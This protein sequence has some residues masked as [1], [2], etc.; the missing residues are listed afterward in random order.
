MT[1]IIIK[2]AK[3]TDGV[4]IR[5]E[6]APTRSWQAFSVHGLPPLLSDMEGKPVSLAKAVQTWNSSVAKKAQTLN[7]ATVSADI[8]K[9]LDQARDARAAAAKTI[10]LPLC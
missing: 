5:F 3:N 4:E 1:S 8:R 9:R 6:Y 10:P 7:T 2:T